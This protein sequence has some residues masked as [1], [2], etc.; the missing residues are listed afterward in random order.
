MNF[1]L[2]SLVAIILFTTGSRPI[3]SAQGDGV[4]V[5]AID[6]AHGGMD[7]GWCE[8]GLSEKEIV[9]DIALMIRE[10]NTRPDL[11]IVLLR[12]T[13]EFLSLKERARRIAEI[14]PD[15][16]LSLHTDDPEHSKYEGLQIFLNKNDSGGKRI[17][18]QLNSAFGTISPVHV[19]QGEEYNLFALNHYP[20][21]SILL[22]FCSKAEPSLLQDPNHRQRIAQAVLESIQ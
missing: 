3:S 1:K 11:K 12:E 13:D 17:S 10:L 9:L 4:M 14:A 7:I 20:A 16:V 8:E 21:P 6:P 18:D 22:E 2:L 5:V 19:R 15:R